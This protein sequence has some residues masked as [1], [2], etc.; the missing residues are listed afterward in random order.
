MLWYFSVRSFST[1]PDGIAMLV[2]NDLCC[3]DV[4]AD[5]DMVTTRSMAA[6]RRDEND[7]SIAQASVSEPTE[8]NLS[9][10]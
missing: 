2:G 6:A 9:D 4:I 10:F 8:Q 3:D 7:L 1:L 5:V